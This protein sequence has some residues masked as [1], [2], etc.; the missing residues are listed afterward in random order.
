MRRR[1]LLVALGGLAVLVAVGVF[2]LW[3]QAHPVTEENF[4]RITVGM[5]RAEVD[6]IVGPAG[7]YATGPLRFAGPT[8]MVFSGEPSPPSEY[9]LSVRDAK[10]HDIVQWRNDRGILT[11]YFD[12]AGQVY[13]K[14]F[15]HV[16]RVEQDPLDNLLWRARRLWRKWFR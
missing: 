11:V 3:P 7:D 15:L 12:R 1:K 13:T 4:G 14:G 6:A 5:G 16:E 10:G 2:V 8:L 9:V